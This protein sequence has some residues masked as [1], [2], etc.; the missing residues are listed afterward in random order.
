MID[1]LNHCHDNVLAANFGFHRKSQSQ[2]EIFLE[3]DV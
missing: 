2:G 3:T 1:I